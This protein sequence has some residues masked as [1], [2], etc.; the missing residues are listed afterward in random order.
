M[1]LDRIDYD[2]DY[3][4]RNCRWATLTEQANNTPLNVRISY[5]GESLT[6]AQWS[7]RLGINRA[8]ID[9]RLAA[10]HAISD[11]LALHKHTRNRT[12]LKLAEPSEL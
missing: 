11:V 5:Q 7:K 10:G 9:R 8:T 4:P 12:P 3:E 2:G 6:V 1:S